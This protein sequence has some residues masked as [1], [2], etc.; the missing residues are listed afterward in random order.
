MKV[1]LGSLAI[2]VV[3]FLCRHH[4]VVGIRFVI[5]K[6]EC[7]SHQVQYAKDTLHV[8]FVV[9]KVDASWQQTTDG[10]DI[11]V[12]THSIYML[13]NYRQKHFFSLQILY[14][15]SILSLSLFNLLLILS[16]KIH[17]L[18]DFIPGPN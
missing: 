6:Q 14:Q 7:F 8:S 10:V 9:I 3:I 16:L 11:V 18:I 13:I 15:I 2:V 5:D 12:S 17:I 4:S 1:G